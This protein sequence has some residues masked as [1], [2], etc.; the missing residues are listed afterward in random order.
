MIYAKIC[1]QMNTFGNWLANE[2]KLREMS[3]ADLARSSKLTRAAISN[4]INGMRGP[5]PDAINA[6]AAALM[7]D[8]KYVMQVAGLLPPEKGKPNQ[9]IQ[10]IIQLAE[11]IPAPEQH[12]LLEIVRAYTK[13]YIDP[14]PHE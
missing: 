10:E 3:Q 14:D 7:L 12:H 6:I 5:G 1:Y 8:P 4:L 13:R 9:T 11:R 2:I